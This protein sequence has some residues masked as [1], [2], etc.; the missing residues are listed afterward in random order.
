MVRSKALRALKDAWRIFVPSLVLFWVVFEGISILELV[1]YPAS[2]NQ[3]YTISGL[4]R[5][6][7]LMLAPFS[8]AL[9]LGILYSRWIWV[10]LSFVIRRSSTVGSVARLLREAFKPLTSF[11]TGQSLFR[12]NTRLFLLVSFGLAAFVAYFPYR[13]DLN[14]SG[15]PV[16][17][18]VN[19]YVDWVSRMVRRSP[20]DALAYAF[21]GPG[22]SSRPLLLIALYSVASILHIQPDLVVKALPVFLATGL[23]GSSYSF[24]RLGS[25]NQR[26]AAL[27]AALTAS[28]S[29]ITVGIWASYY[30]NWLAL[31]ETYLFLGVLLSSVRSPSTRKQVVLVSLSLALLFTHPWT[32]ILIMA[33]TGGFIASHWRSDGFRPLLLSFAGIF[34]VN[35][36]VESVKT[37]ALSAFGVPAAGEYLVGQT[38]NLFS[39]LLAIWPNT[40]DGIMLTYSGLLA[41]AVMLGLALLYM[42]KLRFVD[43][44]QRLLLSWVLVTSVVFPLLSGYLQTRIVY[45]LPVPVLAAGGLMMILSKRESRGLAKAFLLLAVVLLNLSYAIRSM[46]LV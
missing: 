1:F 7:F 42:L 35:I 30:A 13:A 15:V 11:V 43:N 44:F 28:S 26:M 12:L 19:M 32:W 46:L 38:T 4:D 36:V 41:T 16:G 22:P 23:V 3:H 2:A 17:L 29:A 34:L 18:D 39:N 24:V 8:P 45:D 5:D 37:L 33:V 40:I 31:I 21:S 9:L 10:G 20:L 27:S 6:L 25:V 14:P